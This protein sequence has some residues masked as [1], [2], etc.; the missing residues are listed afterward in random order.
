MPASKLAVAVFAWLALTMPA[1]AASL[2]TPVE[3]VVAPG[4]NVVYYIMSLPGKDSMGNPNLALEAGL[5]GNSSFSV[6]L[7]ST[8]SND[9]K[10]N[11][12]GFSNLSLSPDSKT[13]YFQTSAW[14]T[15]DAV[16]SLDIATKRV[17][18]VTDGRIACVVLG[19]QYQGDLVVEQH[20]YFIQGGSHDDLYLYDAA[21]KQIGL[22][23]QDTD[24]SKVCPSLGK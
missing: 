10:K 18:Y 9:P 1:R 8:P 24:A 11:L 4:G 19:G 6:L 2:N 3:H 21:G 7:I 5:N 22:V 16:H 14:A 13:L 20:R 17:S 23:S 15:S 12:D